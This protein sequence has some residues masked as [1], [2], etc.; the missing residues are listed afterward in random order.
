MSKKQILHD[1]EKLQIQL[2]SEGFRNLSDVLLENYDSFDEDMLETLEAEAE[3]ENRDLW[4]SM[5]MQ[6]KFNEKF[7]N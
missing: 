6:R 2:D 5:Q 4:D 7:E 1:V 3:R